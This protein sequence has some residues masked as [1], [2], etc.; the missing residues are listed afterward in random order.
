MA[1]KLPNPWGLYDMHGN[2]WEWCQDYGDL[3]YYSRSPV[4]DPI[5]DTE[6]GSHVVR[7]AS[8]IHYEDKLRLAYY[9]IFG[10]DGRLHDCGFRLA[11]ER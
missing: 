5:N 1:Q 8:Y 4:D 3:E 9:D 7:G 2:V 10:T 11:Q 6:S